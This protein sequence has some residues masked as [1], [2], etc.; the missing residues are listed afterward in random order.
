MAFG[1]SAWFDANSERHVREIWRCLHEK[2]I[3]STLH[4]GPYRPHIT[5]G[6]FDSLDVSR[7]VTA[8]QKELHEFGPLP[9]ILPSVGIFNE[10]LAGFFNVT[11][12]EQ[13][14]RIHKLI[15]QTMSTHGSDPVLYYLPNRWN[16]HCTLAPMLTPETLPE[17]VRHTTALSL[18]IAGIID[19]VGIIDTPAEIELAE[20]P[21]ADS[22]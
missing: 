13:L 6:I 12:T 5:F 7:F 17:F 15:H 16:P 21:L 8:M 18:P 19:R 10:P 4:A 1:V 14:L 22:D 3:D 11:V 20:I 2:G 9:F